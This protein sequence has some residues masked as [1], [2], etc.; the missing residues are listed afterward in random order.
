MLKKTRREFLCDAGLGAG[1][2]LLVGSSWGCKKSANCDD[3]SGL[4]D[5]QKAVRK[6]LQYVG[7]S[8]VAGKNC[9]NCK[10]YNKPAAEG[11]CG[12]CQLFEGPVAAAGYC[13]GWQEA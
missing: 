6:G 10:L 3:V 1:A 13:T 7:Q 5:A 9:A 2:V 8:N 4:S 12:G 11:Q